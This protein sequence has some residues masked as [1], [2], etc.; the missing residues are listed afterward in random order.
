MLVPAIRG[1]TRLI[2]DVP[3]GIIYVY[4]PRAT[5]TEPQIA[6]QFQTGLNL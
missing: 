3:D 1:D 5:G 6:T 4:H 2:T